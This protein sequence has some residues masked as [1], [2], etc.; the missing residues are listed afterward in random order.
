MQLINNKISSKIIYEDSDIVLFPISITRFAAEE[1]RKAL[2]DAGIKA[3]IIHQLWI[4]PFIFKEE[5]KNALNN[6]K[7]GGIILDDD[8]ID[9]VGRCIAHEMMIQSNKKVFAMGL[10]DR[11][12]GFHK[13][14]DNLPPTAEEIVSKVLDL[15][16]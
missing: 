13:S 7:F 15:V 9:G 4:K 5:W 1:A 14:V 6:S 3:S 16:R 2:L 11:S 12:A 10:K 8:Y